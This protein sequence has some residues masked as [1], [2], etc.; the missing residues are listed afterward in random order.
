[1]SKWT[2]IATV[3]KDKNGKNN[4]VFGKD[5]EIL[6]GGEKL[7]L[8]QYRMAKLFN[9]ADSVLSLQTQGKIDNETAEKRLG[10]INDKN[11]TFDVVIP[12]TTKG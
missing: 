2:K 8:D 11:I 9:S 12:P 5:V 7:Q 3:R 10:Y 6:V 1:M 4:I